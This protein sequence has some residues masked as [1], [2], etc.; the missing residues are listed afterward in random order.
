VSL[1]VLLLLDDV[2]DNLLLLDRFLELG[3]V[4]IDGTMMN[5][6]EPIRWS[7]G[8]RE[9]AWGIGRGLED[10]ARS[11]DPTDAYI[12]LST[13]SITGTAVGTVGIR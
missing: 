9:R 3:M 6:G 4:S 8:D 2:E 1:L 13:V 7:A 12:G 10:Q 11:G 5:S